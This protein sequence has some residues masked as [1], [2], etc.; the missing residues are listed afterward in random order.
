MIVIAT[1]NGGYH[2]PLLLESLNAL[3]YKI[4]VSIIDTQS[5]D[6]D[7]INFL[8][9]IDI[10][11]YKFNISIYQTPYKGYDTGAYIYAIKN[12]KNVDRFYFIHDSI[13][14]KDI[15]LF[16][17][18]DKILTSGNVV[19]LL[20]FTVGFDNQEQ[21]DFCNNHFGS[22]YYKY[23]IFGPMFSILRSD[24]DLIDDKFLIYPTNKN[25]QMTMERGWSIL[26]NNYNFNII[27]IYNYDYNRIVNDD[28]L[29]FKKTL[30]SRK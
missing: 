9:N 7:S 22:T 18:I 29:L 3:D 17:E 24:V 16:D 15:K 14:I 1:N 23:G 27:P 4:D 6:I 25:I 21:I 10:K 2:L 8:E 28:Y 13:I 30:G 26:F 19:P 5:N 11:N 20:G 12:I